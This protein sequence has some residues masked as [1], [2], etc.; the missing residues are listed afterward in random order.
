VSLLVVVFVLFQVS[1]T[2]DLLK[3]ATVVFVPDAT[4][5][6]VAGA[7]VLL[8]ASMELLVDDD[9]VGSSAFR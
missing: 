8:F 4:V 1:A 5:E 3:P 9:S 2:H 6:E 7:E